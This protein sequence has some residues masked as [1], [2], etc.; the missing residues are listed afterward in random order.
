MGG[1]G[2]GSPPVIMGGG[3]RMPAGGIGGG[4]MLPT[5][6]DGGGGMPG[7]PWGPSWRAAQHTTH[8]HVDNVKVYG[9]D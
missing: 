1:G 3:G 2:R 6:A 5:L 9:P 8:R 7:S 4:G